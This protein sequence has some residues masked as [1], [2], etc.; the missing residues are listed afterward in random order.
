MRLIKAASAASVSSPQDIALTVALTRRLIDIQSLSAVNSVLAALE[1]PSATGLDAKNL[2]AAGFHAN[3]LANAGFDFASL[4]M[5]GFD[6][7][8]LKA[9][10]QEVIATATQRLT[11]GGTINGSTFN[12]W[13]CSGDG[14]VSLVK[15]LLMVD[16]DCVNKL[17]D[18]GQIWPTRAK[19]RSG[20]VY[21]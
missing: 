12:I 7:A 11:R 15:D 20:L 2:K 21:R 10:F 5:V 8:S 9:A 14:Q 3:E 19:L 17:G 1:H 13:N 6:N 18:L 16:P 4:K